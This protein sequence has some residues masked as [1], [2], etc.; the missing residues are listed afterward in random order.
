M[1]VTHCISSG[2]AHQH[3][4]IYTEESK[5]ILILNLAIKFHAVTYERSALFI[6]SH[7]ISQMKKAPLAGPPSA[8]NISATGGRQVA[9]ANNCQFLGIITASIA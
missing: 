9:P 7:R 1:A 8:S 6:A 4:A 2:S 3:G 5:K